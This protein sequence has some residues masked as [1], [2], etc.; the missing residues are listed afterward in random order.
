MFNFF[1]NCRLSNTFRLI[2]NF[3]WIIVEDSDIKTLL[4]ANLLLKSHLNY[5]HLAIGTPNEWKRKLK[6]C[7][8]NYLVKKKS[9]KEI[10]NFRNPNGKNQGELNKEI[11]H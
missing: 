2:N 8:N 4:V 1:W 5:T 11:K 7:N 3:H 10:V 6:V 9:F